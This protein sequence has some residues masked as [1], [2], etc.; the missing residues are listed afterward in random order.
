MPITNVSVVR[1]Y[2]EEVLGGRGD[3]KVLDEIAV[4][5]YHEHHPFPGHDQGIK[6]LRQRVTTLRAA[7]EGTFHLEHV[8][9]DGKTVAVHWTQSAKHV[10]PFKGMAATGKTYVMDGIDIITM[11]DKR[12]AAHWH[13]ID[14]L[15]MMI[16]LGIIAPPRAKAA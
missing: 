11:R 6:G 13:V 7:F 3:L 4:E 16:Q 1:R 8:I 12:M 14:A 2:Y 10:G 15:G 5:D 9:D